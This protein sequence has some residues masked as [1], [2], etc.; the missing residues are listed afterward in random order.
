MASTKRTPKPK[1][2]PDVIFQKELWLVL[3]IYN[4]ARTVICDTR[5]RLRA[6]ATVEP[7]EYAASGYG[8]I[9]TKNQSSRLTM[10]GLHVWPT[11]KGRDL[12]TEVK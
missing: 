3:H 8:S 7:G 5:R 1:P 6:G 11:K 12:C 9:P 2:A 4:L 10:F